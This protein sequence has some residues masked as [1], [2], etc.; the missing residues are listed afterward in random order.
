MFGNIDW[1]K[2]NFELVVFAIIGISLLP[3]AF[4]FI[5]HKLKQG[6]N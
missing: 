2:K 4:E 1:V 5:K 3:I 6:K